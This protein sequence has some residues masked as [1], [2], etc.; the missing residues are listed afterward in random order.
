M[1]IEAIGSGSSVPEQRR[2]ANE[3]NMSKADIP[4]E[5]DFQGGRRGLYTA[6]YAS[7][8][9]MV[10]LAPDVARTFK[11]AEQVNRV[12]RT[13]IAAAAEIAPV[14][15]PVTPKSSGRR[16]SRQHTA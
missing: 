13:F 10:A 8:T 1:R 11:T 5:V 2:G 7:G 6:R 4:K 14:K 3:S 12:L 15:R 9:N 16:A